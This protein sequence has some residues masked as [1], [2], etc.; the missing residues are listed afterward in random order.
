MMRTSQ[1]MMDQ[2]YAFVET[3]DAI[4]VFAMEGSRMNPE[5]VA[6]AY[7]D[8]D[9]TFFVEKLDR[10]IKDESWLD[11]FG[12]RTL[13]Q[14]PDAM[15]L[16]EAGE[17]GFS[18]LILFADGQKMD[19]TLN[20]LTDLN[21][22]LAEEPLGT[23]LV[24]KDGR[25]DEAV[26]ADASKFHLKKPSAAEFDDCC[27]EFWWVTTYVSKGLL[28]HEFLFA[29]DHLNEI[30]RKELFRMLSWQVGLAFGFDRSIGKNDKFLPKYLA[31]DTWETIVKSFDLSSEEAVWKAL[32]SLVVLFKEV[33]VGVAEKLGYDYP[34]YADNIQP[35]LEKQYED[36]RS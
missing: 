4:R 11:Y 3:H 26:V 17:F 25:L 19:L 13:V 15:E 12:E 21:T 2:L 14:K 36:Y 35:Y 8:F 27:N 9:V 32:F 23:V 20:E 30:V 29:V 5:I 24:D 6:D 1:E 34:D 16:F 28:R 22:Y 31:A 18:Y 7:Q 33:S 10:W